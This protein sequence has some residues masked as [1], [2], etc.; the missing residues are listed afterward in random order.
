VRYAT[1]RRCCQLVPA[2]TSRRRF[3]PV[4]LSAI[5]AIQCGGNT[6]GPTPIPPPPAALSLSCPAPQS[7]LSPTG[8]PVA[9]TYTAPV[10]TGGTAPIATACSPVSGATFALGSTAVS[11]NA[12]DARQQTA[13]CSFTVTVTPPPRLSITR[14]IAFGDSITEGF[15]HTLVPTLVDPAPVGSYPATLLALL[16]AR[17]TANTVDVFDEGLGGELVAN[18]LLRLQAVLNGQPLGGAMLLLEG[19][20][21]LNQ[22]GAAGVAPAVSGLRQMI[23]AARFRSM[24]VFAATLLPQRANGTPARAAHPELVVPM[25]DQ[26]RTMAAAEGAILVDLYQAF[27]GVADN[28]LISSDGLHPTTAG[29]AKIAQTFYDAIRARFEVAALARSW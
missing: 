22:Y 11:C 7:T 13:T 15:P 6:G 12:V 14:Y 24:T 17:Y 27:G 10:A 18:G 5:A 25:N 1:I 9:V 2:F 29:N 16:R 26:I 28:V 4:F 20:N 3:V 23:R 19:A 8:L 21:D